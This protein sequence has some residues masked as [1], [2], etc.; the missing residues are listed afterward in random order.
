MEYTFLTEKSEYVF[1]AAVGV[2]VTSEAARRAS[3]QIRHGVS[4]QRY[5]IPAGK[6]LRVRNVLLT[7]QPKP[8]TDKRVER[9]LTAALSRLGKPVSP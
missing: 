8:K 7:F 6:T 3:V 1:G 5:I 9:A 2:Y 4:T